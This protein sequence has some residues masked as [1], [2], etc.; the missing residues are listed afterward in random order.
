MRFRFRV[1]ACVCV[2]VTRAIA[3]VHVCKGS[4]VLCVDVCTSWSTFSAAGCG[5]LSAAPPVQ[6]VP[7][8]IDALKPAAL[9]TKARLGPA[10]PPP[11]RSKQI[12]RGHSDRPPAGRPSPPPPS[13][14][15]SARGRGALERRRFPTRARC[16]TAAKHKRR[17]LDPVLCRRADVCFQPP[18]S[19]VLPFPETPLS[20]A[21]TGRR[22]EERRRSAAAVACVY[23]HPAQPNV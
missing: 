15:G 8:R 12:A 14:S 20:C 2:C 17:A 4:E 19:P 18:T 3:H 9:N 6:P 7:S 13:S 10:P 16:T 22:E 5:F 21:S 23:F 11:P 1:P